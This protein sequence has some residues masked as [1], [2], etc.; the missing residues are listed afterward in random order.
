VAVPP[1]PEASLL[2]RRSL[3]PLGC[4]G[5][6]AL[7]TL[8]LGV[9]TAPGIDAPS[10][11]FQTW[12]YAHGGFE[13]WN[14]YWYAGRYE[15]VN[16]SMLYYAVAAHVGQL[17]VLVPAGGVL[18]GS[19]AVVC[20]REWGTAARGPSIAFAAT[21]PFIMMVGGTYPF[22]AGAAAAMAALMLVQ[23]GRRL[24][25]GLATFVT[26]AFSPLAFSIL[27]AL[28]AGALLGQRRPFDVL[29]RQRV[30]FAAVVLVFVV[31]VLLQRAFPSQGWYPYDLWD[32]FLVL[33][34]SLAGLWIAGTQANTRTL[35]ALFMAYLALNLMAFLLKGP[36]GSNPSRLFAIAGAPM[37]WLAA[38][39]GPRRRLVVV[40]IIALAVAVQVG[41]KVRDAYSA[42]ENP[43]ASRAYWK[44]ALKF[45]ADHRQQLSGYRVEAVSTW[46]HWDAYYIANQRVPLARGWFRQEDFPQND[47]LYRD[48]L[49]PGVFQHWLRSLGVRYV[50]LP[51]APLDY[52]S[53][54]E[55]RLLRSGRS[56]LVVVS[57]TPHWTFYELPS[58]TPIVTAPPGRHAQLTYFGQQRVVLW[59]SGPG[60]YVV[61]VRYTPYRRA[62]PS[63][64]CL[65]PTAD[66]MTAVTT[67]M[68]GFVQM[69]IDT[70]ASTVAASAAADE[71]ASC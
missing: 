33:V 3:L 61:R 55:A 5:L 29:R 60:R 36:I 44:P 67:H 69:D 35:R 71:T 4:G 30:A 13:I 24:R 43:A 20:R 14:N 31:G 56:G 16:Y 59:T 53:V 9:F 37:L 62:L 54:R 42:W 51:D 23:R 22:F 17:G 45:I 10:H 64:A 19:F 21:A 28:L 40:P 70:D 65:S 50:L 25:F 32:A 58:A 7:V 57:Q 63:S 38:N 49:T 18:G 11:L 46:G 8:V 34:F 68:L 15:F 66:G 41:P 1:H 52:S 27:C 12:L 26:L 47:L 48:R 2:L 6:A 39:V